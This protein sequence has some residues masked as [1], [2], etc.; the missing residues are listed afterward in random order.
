MAS[1]Q[2]DSG[3]RLL[4]ETG[5]ARIFPIPR[6]SRKRS[7][8]EIHANVRRPRMVESLEKKRPEKQEPELGIHENSYRE[9]ATASGNSASISRCSLQRQDLMQEPYE[10]NV[11]VRICAGGVW[12]QTSLPRHPMEELGG[13]NLYNFVSNNPI[14]KR[15]GLGLKE[16]KCCCIEEPEKCFIMIFWSG[17]YFKMDKGNYVMED[18]NIAVPYHFD[19][20]VKMIAILFHEGND[21]TSGC[22]L[23]QS[24][25]KKN[26][27]GDP[28]LRHLTD[29][30]DF[31]SD[32]E[33]KEGTIEYDPE[34]KYRVFYGDTWFFDWTQDEYYSETPLQN[35]TIEFKAHVYVEEV[36][37]V[38][39]WWGYSAEINFPKKS[40]SRWRG[41]KKK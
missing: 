9:M 8:A 34:Q 22:H 2:T 32:M 37:Q 20:Q 29:P 31:A 28:K 12:Q 36:P 33:P 10:L 26:N 11:Q 24:S 40:F 18:T 19:L 17:T 39:T 15:D 4:A 25:D 27:F 6:H 21:D 30:D 14:D 23:H 38:E 5:T 7:S 1:T 16:N 13:E 41:E 35:A 3:A